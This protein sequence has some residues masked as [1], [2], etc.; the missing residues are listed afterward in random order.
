MT[1]FKHV[2]KQGNSGG[3]WGLFIMSQV[4]QMLYAVAGHQYIPI[5]FFCNAVLLPAGLLSFHWPM[6]LNPSWVICC[7]VGIYHISCL[8]LTKGE[9]EINSYQKESAFKKTWWGILRSYWL[10]WQKYP[11]Y[12]QYIAYL[13]YTYVQIILTM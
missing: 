7:H 13:L 5:S 8:P 1:W 2:Y 6:V 11:N 12:I 10:P 9:E 4:G 3:G